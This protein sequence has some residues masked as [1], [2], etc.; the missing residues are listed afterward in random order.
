MKNQILYSLPGKTLSVYHLNRVADVNAH[1]KE[2]EHK[3]LDMRIAE[4]S[5]DASPH[6]KE[7]GRERD[8]GIKKDSVGK[9]YGQEVCSFLYERIC[10]VM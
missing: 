9:K 1:A 8:R 3:I 5:L 4:A 6:I 7:L 2:V 10:S